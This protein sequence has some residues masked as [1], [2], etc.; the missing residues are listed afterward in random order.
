MLINKKNCAGLQL[1]DFVPNYFARDHTGKPQPKYN[2]FGTLK[3]LRY[4][5]NVGDKDRFGVKY[6]L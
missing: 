5:G 3:Y 4:D 6:M 2:I 1:A